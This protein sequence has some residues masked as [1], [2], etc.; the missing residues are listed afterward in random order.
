MPLSKLNVPF[1]TSHFCRYVSKNL[2]PNI[3]METEEH[4]KRS[5]KIFFIA[6]KVLAVSTIFILLKKTG[7][8]PFRSIDWSR[9][10]SPKNP[11][12]LD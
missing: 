7:L 8:D 11:F 2:L 4:I 5:W 1:Q 9:F 6:R 12:H 10:D 3:L